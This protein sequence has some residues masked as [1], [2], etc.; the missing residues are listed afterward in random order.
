[1]GPGVREVR[2][3]SRVP[4]RVELAGRGPIQ[5]V[6]RIVPRVHFHIFFSFL[7]FPFSVFLISFISFA[8]VIQ[9][10]SN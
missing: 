9:I 7:L 8:F 6:G 2:E 4:V 3:G 1:V 5:G 10:D